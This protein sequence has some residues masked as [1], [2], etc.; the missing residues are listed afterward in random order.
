MALIRKRSVKARAARRST[1]QTVSQKPRTVDE[2]LASIPEARR[3]ALEKLRQ[4]LRKLLPGAEEC[5]SYSM[6]AFR[7][8]GRVVAGFQ[9][10]SKGCSCYPFSGTTLT[11]LAAELSDYSQTKSA[12][13]F[14]P[15]RGLPNALLKKLLSA[16][17]AEPK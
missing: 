3:H 1:Q 14:D 7:V 8:H 6:P 5:I 11:A 4:Q 2:Y 9:A 16:R 17:L 15:Q 12:L 13:H 10:T